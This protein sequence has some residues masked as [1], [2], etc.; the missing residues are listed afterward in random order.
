MEIDGHRIGVPEGDEL[1]WSSELH[2]VYFAYLQSGTVPPPVFPPAPSS[3][4]FPF[5]S[6]YSPSRGFNFAV[7]PNHLLSLQQAYYTFQFGK[8]HSDYEKLLNISPGSGTG[9]RIRVK[10][11]DSGLSSAGTGAA[12]ARVISEKSTVDTFTTPPTEDEQGHGTAV[13]EIIHKLAPG[14]EFLIFK[15]C[16]TGRPVEWDVLAALC[17][18]SQASVLNLSLAYG[19]PTAHCVKCGNQSH[20]SRSPV[21][22]NILERIVVTNPN[23]IVVCAAGNAGASNLAYPARFADATALGSIDHNTVRSNFSNYGA[24]DHN[25]QPHANLFFAPGGGSKEYVGSVMP[26]NI[27]QQGTSFSAAYA[28]GLIACM[29]SEPGYAGVR[30]GK[31]LDD[32]RTLSNTST[33]MKHF[34]AAEDG[35]GMLHR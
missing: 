32:L 25:Q 14:A 12:R 35:N 17:D 27:D 26:G 33:N 9:S 34:K 3:W 23:A 5:P 28:S 20:S 24:K 22:E 30:A 10:V 7:A 8:H 1:W 19:L 13:V 4:N 15:V 18:S 6:P 21:F 16:G 2:N 29:Q 31:L 11:L